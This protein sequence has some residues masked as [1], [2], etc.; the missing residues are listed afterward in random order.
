MR[1]GKRAASKSHVHSS[2]NH[3]L[4]ELLFVHSRLERL[5]VFATPKALLAHA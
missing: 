5:A 3:A 1:E 2:R 4:F